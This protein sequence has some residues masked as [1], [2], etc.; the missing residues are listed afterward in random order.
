MVELELVG[1][2]EDGTRLV[3]A[4]AAGDE[5]TVPMDDRLR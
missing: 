3:L 5:F 4:D 1:L 2:S